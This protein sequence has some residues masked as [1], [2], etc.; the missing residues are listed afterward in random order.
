VLVVAAADKVAVA[1]A[2]AVV[3]VAIEQHQVLQYRL[4]SQLLLLSAVGALEAQ[5]LMA[6]VVVILCLA[7]L[8]LQQVAVAV[9]IEALDFRAV[10]EVVAV[11][12]L[13]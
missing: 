3:L 7:P 1:V 11:V 5:L 9:E 2:V 4:A 13:A 6:L 10:L 8:L 12:A